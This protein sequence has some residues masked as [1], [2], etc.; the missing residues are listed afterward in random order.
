[1]T[2]MDI[3]AEGWEMCGTDLFDQAD[4]ILAAILDILFD[5]EIQ[6]MGISTKGHGNIYSKEHKAV[7]EEKILSRGSN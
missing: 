6:P 4:E 7:I 5:Q 3:P 2:E 1:M